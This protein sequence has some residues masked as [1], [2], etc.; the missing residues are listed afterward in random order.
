MKRKSA[1]RSK[2]RRAERLVEQSGNPGD[3][4]TIGRS[5]RHGTDV[6]VE[7]VDQRVVGQGQDAT[8]YDD[9][10]LDHA[11][12]QWRVGDWAGLTQLTA[13]L[14]EDHPQRARLA[15]LA[16]A[17]H[18]ALGHAAPTRL[19][20]RLARQWGCD[21]SLIARTLIAGVHNTL[22][23][24]AAAIGLQQ[25]R[26]LRHFGAAVAPGVS[27]TGE[28]LIRQ[29]RI[30]H[31]L[32]QMGL[33]SDLKDLC[34]PI[35][36][37]PRAP[38]LPNPFVD[39]S[40]QLRKQNDIT[41][42]ALKSQQTELA[43]ARKQIENA[44]KVELSNAIRQLESYAEI[45]AYLSTGQRMPPMHGWPISP[46]F[47]VLLVQIVESQDF[48]AVIEFGSGSSTLLIA[49]ALA[50]R[51]RRRAEPRKTRHLAF[52]HLKEY[53]SSTQDLLDR[54]ELENQVE[55]IFAPLAPFN[56]MDGN[57]YSYYACDSS[58]NE[59]AMEM[60]SRAETNFL[61]VVDGPPGPTGPFARCPAAEVVLRAF[62]STAGA[63]LL[64]DYGRADEKEVARRWMELLNSTGR[65]PS[66]TEYDLEKKACLI[67]F[68]R[69]GS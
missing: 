61:V 59:L 7:S 29:H 67:R 8:P 10:L 25:E 19:F 2:F 49:R 39:L 22:G 48:D 65:N 62:H 12:E 69:L 14:I 47:A 1:A 23:R 45:Q 34:G 20:V 57:I 6:S 31:Q 26:A 38:A 21:H 56:S 55:L 42:A 43:N 58:L 35:L 63:L 51:A 30:D 52:E 24:A 5:S 40:E 68:D 46:D 60:S 36:Q 15:L 3:Q 4:G 28:R 37:V 54:A 66:L 18:H 41:V 50:N 9:G 44:F 33:K 16:A 13:D 32:N 27:G 64:D 53:V 11:R 17:G